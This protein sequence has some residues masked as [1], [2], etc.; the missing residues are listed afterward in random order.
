MGIRYSLPG[1]TD[2]R[3]IGVK[4]YSTMVYN[5]MVKASVAGLLHKLGRKPSEYRH[6][7]LHQNDV[8]T[9]SSL[10]KKLG[11]TEEQVKEG[12]VFPYVGD[13]G[14]CSALIGLCRVLNGTVNG[15]KIIIC[16][17]G[18]G[19]GSQALSFQLENQIPKSI[20]TFE[21][22]LDRKKYINYVYYLKL[23]RNI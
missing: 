7:I 3:D 18:S 23:K 11:F 22:L 14:A 21:A 19:A 17:Y 13:T 16:S 9:A 8:K 6:V 5:E 10:A 4:T 1:E 12:M 2:V 20:K 15:D